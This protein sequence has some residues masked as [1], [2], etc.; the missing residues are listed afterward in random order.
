MA[1]R[2]ACRRLR[3]KELPRK[4]T[5]QHGKIQFINMLPQCNSVKIRGE[6]IQKEGGTRRRPM[7]RDY[8][9]AKD[10]EVGS[11]EKKESME[12]NG[13]RCKVYRSYIERA[14]NAAVC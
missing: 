5:E 1:E 10:A 12:Q 3:T 13:L 9:A 11:R 8:A 14:C 7:G 4:G 2:R 6:K